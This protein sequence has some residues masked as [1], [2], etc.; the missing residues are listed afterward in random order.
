MSHA[1]RTGR[2]E[3]LS[4]GGLALPA[5]LL[6]LLKW[7][8]EWLHSAVLWYLAHCQ[9]LALFIVGHMFKR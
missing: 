5:G 7:Q 2:S 4:L 1:H 9:A 3:S 6:A 8:P